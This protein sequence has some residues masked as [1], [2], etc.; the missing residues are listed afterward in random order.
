MLTGSDPIGN[1]MLQAQSS[2]FDGRIGRQINMQCLVAGSHLQWLHN[3]RGG[4]MSFREFRYF[5][6]GLIPL[7]WDLQHSQT[8][9]RQQA[10]LCNSRSARYICTYVHDKQGSLWRNVPQLTPLLCSVSRL[11]PKYRDFGSCGAHSRPLT[12][13]HLFFPEE[14]PRICTCAYYQRPRKAVPDA[15]NSDCLG[16]TCHSKLLIHGIIAHLSNVPLQVLHF[17]ASS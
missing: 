9:Q 17:L 5:P 4:S 1:H 14:T 3:H 16:V 6:A 12:A 13:H 10:V 7:S 11:G 15:K 8:R 2:G